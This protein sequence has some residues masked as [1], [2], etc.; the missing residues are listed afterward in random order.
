MPDDDEALSRPARAGQG[1]QK[2]SERVLMEISSF[3]QSNEDDASFSSFFSLSLVSNPKH[4]SIIL[5]GSSWRMDTYRHVRRYVS[6][7]SNASEFISAAAVLV[8][9]YFRNDDEDVLDLHERRKCPSFRE[10]LSDLPAFYLRNSAHL[11]ICVFAFSHLKFAGQQRTSASEG[12]AVDRR[13]PGRPLP[14][15][16]YRVHNGPRLPLPGRQQV[17]SQS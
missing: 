8:F 10:G 17:V 13:A 14:Y 3:E 7:P 15:T 12:I 11:L 6:S 5:R 4:R 2:I 1:Q 16:P 9:F